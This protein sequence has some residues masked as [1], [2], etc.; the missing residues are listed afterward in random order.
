MKNELSQRIKQARTEIGISQAELARRLN[1]SRASVSIWESGGNV[2]QENILKLSDVLKV[3]PEWLQ[4]GI[5]TRNEVD[6]ELLTRCIVEAGQA[7]GEI[8]LDLDEYQQARLVAYL[9]NESVR[10]VTPNRSR[11][12]DLIKV[13]H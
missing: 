3:K 2:S 12:A 8:G 9:Y 6:I 5:E 7:T 11:I 1:I 13:M 4:Y 10:G